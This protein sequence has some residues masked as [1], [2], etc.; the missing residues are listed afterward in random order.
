MKH[1]FLKPLTLTLGFVLIAFSLVLASGCEGSAA[2]SGAISQTSG[3]KA[4]ME[5]V[6]DY[7]VPLAAPVADASAAFDSTPVRGATPI[8]QPPVSRERASEQP[9]P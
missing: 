1:K 8:V 4:E 5:A 6:S 9:N 2:K 7:S 3:A